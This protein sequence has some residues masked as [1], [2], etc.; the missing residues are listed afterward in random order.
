VTLAPGIVR[1]CSNVFS[2]NPFVN[3]K[4]NS[5]PTSVCSIL[6]INATSVVPL[7]SGS[8]FI[9]VDSTYEYLYALRYC[10]PTC[11]D[12]CFGNCKGHGGCDIFNNTCTCDSNVDVDLFDNRDCSLSGIEQMVILG[13]PLAHFVTTIVGLII[14]VVLTPLISYVCLSGGVDESEGEGWQDPAG[15]RLLLRDTGTDL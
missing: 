5:S 12:I 4:Q 14:V 15:R 9:A 6:E 10:S 2:C 11:E 13:L 8:Y 3:E 7:H 1:P